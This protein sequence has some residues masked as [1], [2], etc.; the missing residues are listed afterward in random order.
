M[1]DSEHEVAAYDDAAA[2]VWRVAR[3]VATSLADGV[4][5]V[6]AT[7]SSHRRAIE[8]LLRQMGADPVRATREG[9]LVSLDADETMGRFMVDGHPEPHLFAELVD[10]VVP[11]DGRPVSVYGEMVAVLWER[12]EIVAAL[13]LESLWNTAIEKRPIRLLV[14]LPGR[15]AR[16]RRPGRRGPDV[17][18]PRP[19]QPRRGPPGCGRDADR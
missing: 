6:M 12:G 9:R 16:G 14:L 8:A 1:G 15:A 19:R 18:P 4:P 7:R 5:V 13:E 3:F 10:S 11:A 2:L 17:R